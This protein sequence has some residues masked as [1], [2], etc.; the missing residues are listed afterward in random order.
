M[1]IE[2]GKKVEAVLINPHRWIYFMATEEGSPN[3]T[4]MIEHRDLISYLVHAT[5]LYTYSKG[6]Y[7][8]V[9]WYLT[10]HLIL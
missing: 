2:E 8:T 10:V 9:L 1:W 7:C 4:T 6:C 5:V 3:Q